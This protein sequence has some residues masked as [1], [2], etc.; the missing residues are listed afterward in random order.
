MLNF[1]LWCT[2]WQSGC[3]TPLVL[4]SYNRWKKPVTLMPKIRSGSYAEEK[5]HLTLPDI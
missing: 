4:H 1:P 2:S 3:M 5:N